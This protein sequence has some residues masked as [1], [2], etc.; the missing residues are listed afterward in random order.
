MLFRIDDYPTGIKPVIPN[1]FAEFDKVLSEFEKRKLKYLLG[2]VPYLI[3]EE[4]V[5]YLKNLKYA[6]VA[7]HGYDHNFHTFTE[8]NREEF[9]GWNKSLVN[10]QQYDDFPSETK[11]YIEF[12]TQKLN[13][14][15]SI[16]S[17]GPKRNQIINV[18]L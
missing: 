7:L 15:I 13:V 17:V 11:I 9:K 3:N 2:V 8:L 12:L 6:V 16:I 4:D 1:R 10:I 18:N 5:D 14:P